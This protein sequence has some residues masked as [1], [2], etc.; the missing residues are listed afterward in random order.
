MD[1]TPKENISWV[2]HA[3]TCFCKHTIILIVYP[4][5]LTVGPGILHCRGFSVVQTLCA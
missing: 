2:V 5:A 1:I 3:H 4:L